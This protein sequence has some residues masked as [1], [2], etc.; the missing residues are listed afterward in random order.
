MNFSVTILDLESLA[1]VAA[2]PTTWIRSSNLV[3]IL[4]WLPA[5]LDAYSVSLAIADLSK[6]GNPSWAQNPC[7]ILANL[8]RFSVVAGASS[9]NSTLIL[10]NFLKS[11]SIDNN[12][13]YILALPIKITFKLR[14]IG[15][16]FK[17]I[18]T[19]DERCSTEFSIPTS[20][21]RKAFFKAS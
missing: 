15:S 3:E 11:E 18:R 10:N 9:S 14:G 6:W 19:I 8:L 4:L 2:S 12:V 21:T 17:E 20:L 5:S 7:M 16:G 13:W 1:Q